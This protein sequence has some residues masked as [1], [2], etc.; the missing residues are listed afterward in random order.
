[1]IWL[2]KTA[3]KSVNEVFDPEK[4]DDF[5]E[6]PLK[7][8]QQ[9]L[10]KNRTTNYGVVRQELLDRL[11]E[12]MY[13]QRL[14]EPDERKW[15]YRI[16]SRRIVHGYEKQLNGSLR[17]QL[18][19]T[20]TG[21]ISHTNACFD[22]VI[23]ATGY[24]RDVHAKLLEP[25]KHLLETNGYHVGRDYRVQYRKGEVADDCGVWLQGCCEESH[26]VSYESR[27]FTNSRC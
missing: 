9:T 15:K 25:T 13:H 22:L 16:I 19:N 5:Y 10:K 1:M 17:L 2:T 14:H 11:Y 26:G 4:V 18:E 24:L 27:L 12:N 8:Q 20:V 3:G 21:E 7:A 23:T 6:L